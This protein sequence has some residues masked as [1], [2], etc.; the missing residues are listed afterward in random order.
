M[1]GELQV[2]SYSES[3]DN[4]KLTA[5]DMAGLAVLAFKF[6]FILKLPARAHWQPQAQPEADP[7]RF[8]L[9]L[10]FEAGLEV[11]SYMQKQGKVA[12][13]LEVCTTCPP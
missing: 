6:R 2:E 4:F 3:P 10:N 13:P 12:S 8:N 1:A 7:A 5:E 9:K 11:P